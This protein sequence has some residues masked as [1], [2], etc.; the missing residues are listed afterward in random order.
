MKGVA[1][2][3]RDPRQALLRDRV[4]SSMKATLSNVAIPLIRIAPHCKSISPQC[5]AALTSVA[6]AR[7][8]PP[9][10]D[11]DERFQ[12]GEDEGA[13]AVEQPCNTPRRCPARHTA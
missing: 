6:I 8:G 12:I 4:V 11:T 3:R 2:K 9:V 5:R 13:V 1:H 7:P 10:G